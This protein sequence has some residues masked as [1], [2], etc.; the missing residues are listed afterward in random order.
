[1]ESTICRTLE[2]RSKLDELN[3]DV[4]CFGAAFRDATLP[5]PLSKMVGIAADDC[6]NPLL[7]SLF[8]LFVLNMFS[9]LDVG[10][11][12]NE[13][14]FRN[15]NDLMRLSLD[16]SGAFVE[17]PLDEGDCFW[18]SNNVETNWSNTFK[19]AFIFEF[20]IALGDAV[21]VLIDFPFDE[22]PRRFVIYWNKE[23]NRLNVRQTDKMWIMDEVGK[24]VGMW[25]LMWICDRFDSF[26][27]YYLFFIFF[28]KISSTQK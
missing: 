6:L 8:L 21:G 5:L 9:S 22:S 14:R 28:R 12:L 26:H 18:R 2:R 27:E 15:E 10:F 25:I 23:N 16:G 13:R 20:R 7:L 4:V 11:V 3:A 1:M 17:W 19:S 24:C